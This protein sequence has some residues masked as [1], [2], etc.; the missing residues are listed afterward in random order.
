[1]EKIKGT[2]INR[3]WLVA[4]AVASTAFA[5]QADVIYQGLLIAWDSGVGTN[6]AHT[7]GGIS[8]NL[9]PGTSAGAQ[10]DANSTDGTFGSEFP[11]AEIET[12]WAIAVGDIE[13]HN[14]RIAIRIANDTGY[15]VALDKIHFDAA[16]DWAGSPDTLTLIYSW[17]DLDVPQD[18]VVNSVTGLPQLQG[19][20][21]PGRISDGYANFDWSATGLDDY[22]LAPGEEATFWLLGSN[23]SGT[24]RTIIDN[25]A[26][27]GTIIPPDGYSRITG[28]IPGEGNLVRITATAL[29]PAY[30]ESTTDLTS[31]LWGRI[32][33]STDGEAGFVVT[34]LNYAGQAGSDYV[35]Y[36][37]GEEDARY[38]RLVHGPRALF[39]DVTVAAGMER[40]DNSGSA[41]WVDLNNNGWLDLIAGGRVWIN[42]QGEGFTRG[43]SVGRVVAADFNNNGWTDLFSYSRQRFFRNEEGTLV[44]DESLIPEFPDPYVS[45]GAVWGDFNGN[46]WVD[47]Y[48]AGYEIWDQHLT[49]PDFLLINNNG[50]S[51]TKTMVNDSYRARGVTACDFD[52]DGNLDIYV[53]NYRLQPNRLWR[54]N[55]SGVFTDVAPSYNARAGNGHSIG[56]CWGDFNNNG[57]F[58]LF[59]G[60]FAHPY[61][62][63]HGSGSWTEPGQPESR[64]LRNR[65]PAHGYHFEDMGPCGVFYQESYASPAAADFDNSGRLDLFFTTVYEIASGGIPNNPVLFR[66]E[67]DFSF[68]PVDD[69]SLADLP[70]TYQAAWGDY[71]NNGQLDLLTGG[72]LLRNRG[73]TT[74]NWLKVRLEG[75]GIAVNRSAI[76]AQVRIS[77]GSETLSRQV[78]GGTGQ[79]NQNSLILHFGLGQ[80]AGPVDLNITWPGGT[81]QTVTGVPLNQLIHV[82]FG[83]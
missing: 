57:L 70:P 80:H 5:V 32:A 60:N 51:F 6:Y 30:P 37:Q 47:L 61:Q 12:V 35:I 10:D 52:Q 81:V 72:K 39:K 64:F 18:A 8:G 33:H 63:V 29:D 71:N 83:D 49:F 31:G 15:D 67:G 56:A 74:N 46:G 62:W 54:N 66:N 78:E 7:A 65:G 41:C 76:G 13:E 22:T 24:A 36:V 43:I 14:N 1:M 25:I 53:S 23:A 73:N 20:G 50:Q 58:D 28:M 55:G 68:V 9:F 75:D 4:M 17:G 42:N 38:F 69:P 40:L 44:E 11:G 26:I 59:A 21:N 2:R 45:R 77:M 48:V 27:S 3:G 34:N 79:G 16:K 82:L 19:A